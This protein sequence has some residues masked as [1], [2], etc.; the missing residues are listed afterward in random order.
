MSPGDKF[1]VNLAG[2]AD[3]TALSVTEEPDL[4]KAS[5]VLSLKQEKRVPK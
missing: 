2:A 5:L 4:R 3:G 1:D